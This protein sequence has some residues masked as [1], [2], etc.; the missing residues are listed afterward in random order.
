MLAI[1]FFKV[2]LTLVFIG[3][4]SLQTTDAIAAPEIP[5]AVEQIADKHYFRQ[6]AISLLY[7]KKHDYVK[8]FNCDNVMDLS[9]A[10]NGSRLDVICLRANNS[11]LNLSIVLKNNAY[12]VYV[13]VCPAGFD[14]LDPFEIVQYAFVIEPTE[15]NGDMG[16]SHYMG[17]SNGWIKDFENI[18]LTADLGF[19]KSSCWA[20]NKR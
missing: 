5:K 13:M 10:A 8:A 19:A 12:P 7:D 3:F 14:D 15:F 20:L 1:N 4:L 18:F 2:S 9:D 11:V 6:E 16:T 17:R